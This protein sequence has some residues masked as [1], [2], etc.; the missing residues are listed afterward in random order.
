MQLA[1]AARGRWKA[2]ASHVAVWRDAS[3]GRRRPRERRAP[4]GDSSSSS[5]SSDDDAGI[6]FVP[7]PLETLTN[8]LALTNEDAYIAACIAAYGNTLSWLEFTNPAAPDVQLPH[9]FT[10]DVVVGVLT[11]ALRALQHQLF[12]W[13]FCVWRVQVRDRA[14]AC[15]RRDTP[16][17]A[18]PDVAGRGT[19]T[20]A[21]C[22]VASHA[23]YVVLRDGHFV[24]LAAV[25][26]QGGAPGRSH[27]SSGLAAA[28]LTGLLAPPAGGHGAT[29]PRR[30]EDEGVHFTYMT[31]PTSHG[32]LVSHVS[33]LW[34][35]VTYHR[36]LERADLVA[37]V[38]AAR[39]CIALGSGAGGSNKYDRD[40]VLG[41]AYAG[42]P[43][44]VE[45]QQ[46][47]GA[48]RGGVALRT[49]ARARAR[50]K[51]KSSRRA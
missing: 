34:R 7:I 37:H 46:V 40:G 43:G 27:G 15:V 13:G 50:R 35:A 39:P 22:D 19:G 38:S 36:S 49:H 33:R 48:R 8:Y 3:G 9:A 45:L 26:T 6:S 20:L 21:L 41:T 14:C 10:E 32:Q 17:A 18:Q 25:R 24:R 44:G 47:C 12:A 31:L 23:Y 2:G 30:M 16:A 11:P 51:R 5:S 29:D 4:D 1:R 42:D 28:G